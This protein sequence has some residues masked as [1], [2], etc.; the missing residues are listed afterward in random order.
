MKKGSYGIKDWPKDERPREKL[1]KSGEH[2]LSNTELIAILLRNGTKGQSAIELAR[3][4]ISNFK[5]LRKMSHL[6]PRR[7]KEIKGMGPAKIAQVRAALELGRRFNEEEV[8]EDSPKIKSSEDVVEILMPR[9]RDLRKEIFKILLLN[10][11]NKIIDIIEVEE[12]TVNQATPI[13]REVFQK[14]LQHFAASIICVHNHPSG[15]P[16]PSGEDKQFTEELVQAGKILQIKA[17]DHIIIGDNNYF[18]FLDE[19]LPPF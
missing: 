12:G 10:S 3:R 13:I 17:L 19:G 1:F 14:A 16:Q 11:R 2:T 15:D 4:V 18:S 6:D 8:K 7:W 9:M 5:T